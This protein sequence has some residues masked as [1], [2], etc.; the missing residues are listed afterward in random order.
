MLNFETGYPSWPNDKLNSIE[1]YYHYY[2]SQGIAVPDKS[3][4]VERIAESLTII[5]N[6]NLDKE[7]QKSI[8]C[9]ETIPKISIAA[10]LD[11][12]KTYS[13]CSAESYIISLI[14]I[15]RYNHCNTNSCLAPLNAHK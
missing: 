15:D 4:V 1:Y 13:I 10:Y 3:S 14:Y 9:A 5:V 11:R 7:C 8:F 12:I 2:K 6:S